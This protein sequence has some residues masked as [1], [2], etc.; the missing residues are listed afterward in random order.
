MIDTAKILDVAQKK[1]EG[2][3]LFVVEVGSTPAN[4]V[5]VTIDGD[6]PVD[7]DDCVSLSRAIEEHFDRETEDFAL[8]VTSAGVG[9]PL[10]VFRQYKNLTGMPV[11]VVLKSGLKII[12]TLKDATEESITLVWEEMRAVDGKK[13]KQ[14]FEVEKTFALD[15]VKTTR[16]HIDFK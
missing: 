3:P 9:Y 11:E 4:E 8:T 5:E 16:E 13:R 2:T 14:P 12:A 6:R 15:E 10:K 1:L 7:I